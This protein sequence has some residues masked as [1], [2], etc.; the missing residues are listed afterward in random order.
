MTDTKLISKLVEEHL[1]GTGLFLVGV[2]VSGDNDIDVTVEAESRD[3]TL[4]DC[5]ELNNWLESKLDRSVEDH[6]LTVG[7]AGLTQPLKVFK[8]FKKAEGAK[9]EMLL[10]GGRKIKDAVLDKA[11]E[12]RIWVTYSTMETVEGKKRKERV[13]HSEAFAYKDL[14]SVKREIEF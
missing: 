9:V 1:E 6:S 10:S 5:T 13:S 14:L 7:S 4:D 3:V 12:D 2:K 11:D 8:Q